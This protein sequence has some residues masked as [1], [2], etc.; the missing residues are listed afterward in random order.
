MKKL[1]KWIQTKIDAYVIK[2][3]KAL[4]PKNLITELYRKIAKNDL[5]LDIKEVNVKKGKRRYTLLVVKD[6][7][8]KTVFN[9]GR[10]QDSEIYKKEEC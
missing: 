9:I 3:F 1:S 8:C 6:R 7:N 5:Q 10:C 4:L 2:R